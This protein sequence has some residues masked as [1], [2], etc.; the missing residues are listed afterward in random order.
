MNSHQ[1]PLVSIVT[2]VYNGADYL[3]ECIESVL[4]QAY[5]NYEYIVVNNCS[6]DG[7]LQI[8]MDYA[9]KNSRIRVHNNEKFVGVIANHNIAFRLMSSEAKY[10]KVVSADD[11]ILPDCLAR[12]VELAEA[13]PTVGLVGVYQ[14]SGSGVKWQG[15]KYP[16]AVVPGREMCRRIFLG[17]DK[18]FGFGSPTSLLYRAD[19]VR[20]QPDFY[21]NPSPHSDSSACFNCLAESDYGFVYEVLAFER[22]HEATQS[23]A[24]AKIDRFVSANFNDVICYGPLYLSKDEQAGKLA[25]MQGKYHHLLARNLLVG[26]RQKEFWDYHKGRLAELGYPFRRTQLVKAAVRIVWE[27]IKNPV[28]G[29]AKLRTL[30][31]SQQQQKAAR[32]EQK[33]VAAKSVSQ[34]SGA[35]PANK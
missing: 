12:M 18:T 21:P 19:L 10:C 24:S 34:N 31:V 7:T 29:V 33:K 20:K 14:L 4:R 16:Q 35:L 27:E 26:N 8:A 32:A 5:Q 30:V 9:A 2:P 13:N 22:I 11:F 15:L 17:M 25:E 3:A 23:H 28:L 1:Q 6:T